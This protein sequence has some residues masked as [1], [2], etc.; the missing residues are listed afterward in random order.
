MLP[1]RLMVNFASIYAD[2]GLLQTEAQRLL[3]YLTCH[4]AGVEAL[5]A[6][7]LCAFLRV[8]KGL[9][10][11]ET[12]HLSAHC[13]SSTVTG[14]AVAAVIKTMRYCNQLGG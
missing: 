5:T 2:V 10:H 11:C 6:N 9:S 13:L 8:T 7:R 3:A 12:S 4:T 1:L 14:A